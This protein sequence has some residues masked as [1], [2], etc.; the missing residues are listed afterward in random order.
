MSRV[1][2]TGHEL[3]LGT[4]ATTKN[5]YYRLQIFLI[6]LDRVDILDAK[7]LCD[8]QLPH[9]VREDSCAAP[10]GLAAATTHRSR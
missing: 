1:E 2:R 3:A 5:M 8:V 7:E 9:L 10:P 4:A 6:E